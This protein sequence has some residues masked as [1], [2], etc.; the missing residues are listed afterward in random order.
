MKIEEIVTYVKFFFKAADLW[1]EVQFLQEYV[2]C[3]IMKYQRE[4]Y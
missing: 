1:G 3:H 2:L 4:N